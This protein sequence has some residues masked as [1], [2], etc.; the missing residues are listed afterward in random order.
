MSAPTQPFPSAFAAARRWSG[1]LKPL[2]LLPFLVALQFSLIIDH[3]PWRDELQAWLLVRD[4][5]GLAGLFANP[6]YE[7]HPS[8]W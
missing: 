8:L 6:H 5:H 2:H 3:V 7:G 1:R 4:S